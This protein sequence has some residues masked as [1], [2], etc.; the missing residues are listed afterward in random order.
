MRVRRGSAHGLRGP[1]LFEHGN[2]PS[3]GVLTGAQEIKVTPSRDLRS[4]RPRAARR[5]AARA[6]CRAG[7]RS[8]AVVAAELQVVSQ[9]VQRGVADARDLGHRSAILEHPQLVVLVGA[10]EV[11]RAA[12]APEPRPGDLQVLGQSS[13]H[14]SFQIPCA[15]ARPLVGDLVRGL[16]SAGASGVPSE[17]APRRRRAPP[18][19]PSRSRVARRR[20]PAPARARA[21]RRSRP[22]T[23]SRTKS[24]SPS[25]CSHRPLKSTTSSV[26]CTS[27]GDGRDASRGERVAPRRC[28]GAWCSGSTRPAAPGQ[29]HVVRRTP[30]RWP[31]SAAGSARGHHAGM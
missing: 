25:A 28:L 15:S 16:R 3:R 24:T 29:P 8:R 31:A 10:A 14:A 30:R 2:R 9:P 20:R 27:S 12:R 21:D 18:S 5:R 22:R 26:P 23:T 17:R 4:G 1:S 19:R 7:R 6:R 13:C 11:G